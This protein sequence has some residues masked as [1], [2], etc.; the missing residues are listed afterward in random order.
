MAKQYRS[1][2]VAKALGVGIQRVRQMFAI[3]RKKNLIKG[4]ITKKG[5][6]NLY[7]Q[8]FV[9]EMK[10]IQAAGKHFG[11]PRANR[12]PKGKRTKE[13]ASRTDFSKFKPAL[14]HLKKAIESLLKHI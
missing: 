3:V 6:A 7:S 8:K 5:L 13:A 1:D 9:D 2:Q 12:G 11:K 4:G 14:V 10:K